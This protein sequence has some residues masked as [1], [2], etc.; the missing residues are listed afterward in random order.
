MAWGWRERREYRRAM[1]SQWRAMRR[2][3]GHPFNPFA[4]L[5][6]LFWLVFGLAFAFSPEFRYTMI[7]VFR[8]IG[9]AF[10]T[11]FAGY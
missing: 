5:I 6:G 4:P 8:T 10:R 7:D 1:R 2:Q 11:L 9:D 3:H